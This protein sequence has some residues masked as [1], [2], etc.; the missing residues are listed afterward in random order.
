MQVKYFF[1]VMVLL[2]CGDKKDGEI[3]TRTRDTVVCLTETPHKETKEK[4]PIFPA[5]YQIIQSSLAA[6]ATFKLDSYNGSVYQLVATPTGGEDWQ[7][8]RK[9]SH[10]KDD[11]QYDNMSNYTL[12][13]SSIAIKYTYLMNVNTGA[14]WQ[15]A[16]NS[17]SGEILFDPM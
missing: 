4:N 14:V 3:T 15:L 17:E 8:L 2:S 7:L 16:Q 6:K 10:Y 1:L 12:F 13:T 9:K 11:V 5:R